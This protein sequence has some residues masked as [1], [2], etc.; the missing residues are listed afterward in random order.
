MRKE[1]NQVKIAGEVIENF[2]FDHEVYGEKFYVAAVRV[3]R[4]SETHDIIRVMVSERL[5][6]VSADWAGSWIRI[7]GQFRSVNKKQP[8]GRSKLE[9]YVFALEVEALET[10]DV[11]NEDMN[12][13]VLDGYYCKEP[14]YRETPLGRKVTDILFA[15]NRANGKSDYIPCICWGRS[16]LFAARF[17][18]GAH[19]ILNGRIQSRVYRK[20][21][22]DGNYEER[23]AWEVSVHTMQ[24]ADE[25]GEEN[26]EDT[27]DT[28]AE[29]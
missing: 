13:I 18:T 6:D 9:L 25:E 22:E 5:V 1:T 28:N 29:S 3:P 2:T 7:N 8:E 19:F 14:V 20:R 21:L 16:A 15:V 27:N 12:S 10:L 23:T 26:H 17:E 24:L 11:P 4:L